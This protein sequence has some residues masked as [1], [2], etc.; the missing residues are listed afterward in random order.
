VV[1]PVVEAAPLERVVQLAVRLE[2]STTIAAAG[3]RGP[4][5]ARGCHLVRRQHL[6]QERL[7]LVVGPV[8]LVDE[9]H[10][11]ALPQRA[12][13]RPGEQEPLVEQRLLGLLASARRRAAASSARRCRIWR[14][15]SQS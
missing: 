9:Q 7:E 4:C 5:R 10:R 12:Q 3:P 6:E 2:V 8:D 14:G 11:G 15:K 1:D 13:H